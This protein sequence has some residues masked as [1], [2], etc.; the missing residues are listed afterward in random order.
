MAQALADRRRPRP[1]LGPAQLRR[2][3]RVLRGCVGVG[4]AGRHARRAARAP[5]HGAGG[6][7]RWFGRRPG[8]DAR[9][10]SATATWPPALA[11]WWISGAPFGL[12]SLAMHY[13]SGSFQAAWAGGMEAVVE[14]PEWAEVLERNPAN[15]ERFLGAGPGGVHRD[16]G[17]LDGVYCPG[18][19]DVVPGLGADEAR[20]FDLPDPGVPQRRLRHP[21]H[22]GRRRSASP[23]PCRTPAWWSRRGATASGPSDRTSGP[24]ASPTGSSCV[25]RCSS[26][27][28]RS[29][30]RSRR[31]PE[32]ATRKGNG[33][34]P[35][36][37]ATSTT[38]RTTS[39]STATRIRRS[40]ASGRRRRSTTTIA[41]TSTR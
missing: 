23:R 24:A 3:R 7:H 12:M 2:V 28:S 29:G 5:R 4:A 21:P 13:C 17:P 14:L 33:D 41:T 18:E 30:R 39:R 9:R 10:R 34:R 8:L 35:S 31:S 20:A 22:P 36:R 26:R 6:D 15:R 38:T 19:A 1:D 27:S 16:D 11:V 37:R 32:D 40:V 25:G